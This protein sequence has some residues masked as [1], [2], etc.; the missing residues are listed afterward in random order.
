MS[1]KSSMQLTQASKPRLLGSIVGVFF[2]LFADIA[3]AQ[4][5]NADEIIQMR[6]ELNQ[7]RAEQVEAVN[8]IDRLEQLI[9]N[10]SN[11][12]QNDYAPIQ[13][14]PKTR[15]ENIIESD[16]RQNSKLHVSGDF[17]L[18]YEANFEND[19][20]PFRGR[21]VIR[22]RLGV[23]YDFN[24]WVK[25]GAR[26]TT[27][28]FDDP[29][30][31]D[32]SLSGFVDDLPVSLDQIYA[33]FKFGDILA[34]GGKFPNPFKKTGLVWDGD[35][36]PQGITVG[37]KSDSRSGLGWSTN[38]I[39]FIID[40]NVVGADSYMVGGQA[41]LFAS[42]GEVWKFNA[43]AAFYDYTLKN[44]ASAGAGDF[45]SNLR[46]PDGNYLSDFNLVDFIGSITFEGMGSRWPLIVRGDYVHNMGAATN[47]STGYSVDALLGRAKRPGDFR[48]GYAYSQAETDAV[49]AAF[50]HDNTNLPT[51]YR[52]H[53]LNFDYVLAEK[54]FLNATFYHYRPLENSPS[55]LSMD[56]QNRL[57]LNLI[58]SF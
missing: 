55:T 42:F 7:L 54:V 57:R 24:D 51:N 27:G 32:V 47:A 30:S 13:T 46:R 18:R 5:I 49:F 40:E 35:V 19:V 25:L 14:P 6:A 41:S 11:T 58:Y 20:M 15:T 37:Y 43:S 4:D 8:R 16:H 33:Q 9:K 48:F 53:A 2:A 22:G 17:R 1:I 31:A 45:R 52:L 44:V 38:A 10:I 28:N 50:S 23:S 34:S 29:N 3:L 26:I 56:W 21:E 36:N 39:Y 12:A